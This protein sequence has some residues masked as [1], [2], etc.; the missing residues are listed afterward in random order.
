MQI[1]PHHLHHGIVIV[2]CIMVGAVC[3]L[4]HSE[5][6]YCSRPMFVTVMALLGKIKVGDGVVGRSIL[7]QKECCCILKDRSLLPV[8]HQSNSESDTD[9]DSESEGMPDCAVGII[10]IKSTIGGLSGHNKRSCSS[11]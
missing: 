2:Y 10:G 3:I 11:K 6:I 9:S 4:I 5:C 1:S 7:C 8:K